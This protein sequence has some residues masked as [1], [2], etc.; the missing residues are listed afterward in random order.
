MCLLN[1]SFPAPAFLSVDEMDFQV[2]K[3]LFIAPVSQIKHTH[4]LKSLCLGHM[5]PEL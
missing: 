4:D 1:F 2:R 3:P 5:V